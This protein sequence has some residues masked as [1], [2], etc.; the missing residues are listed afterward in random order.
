MTRKGSQADRVLPYDNIAAFVLELS[1]GVL[2]EGR[3]ARARRFETL[4]M[5]SCQQNLKF[6]VILTV[7]RR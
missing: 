2:R 5:F 4:G 1:C 3:P 6:D 7:H